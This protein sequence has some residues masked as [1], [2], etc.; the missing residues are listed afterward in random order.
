MIGR[1]A[2]AVAGK[3]TG[4]ESLEI[5]EGEPQLVEGGARK[6]RRKQAL[7]G[8]PHRHGIAYL[9]GIG[10]VVIVTAILRYQ[11]FVVVPQLCG[12]RGNVHSRLLSGRLGGSYTLTAVCGRDSRPFY[13]FCEPCT[14]GRRRSARWKPACRR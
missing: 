3:T 2:A 5:V 11:F 12:A 10:H 4:K 6:R 1:I 7:D 8:I 14:V 9:D 13:I